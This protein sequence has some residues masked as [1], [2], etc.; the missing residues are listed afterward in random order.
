MK[1]FFSEGEEYRNKL[2]H[3]IKCRINPDFSPDRILDFGCGVGR[4]LLPMAE[5]CSSAVGTDVSR[6]MLEKAVL[7]CKE[8]GLDHVELVQS[9]DDLSQVDGS[10]DFIH[11]IYVFQHIPCSRGYKIFKQLLQKLSP[12]GVAMIQFTYD[13]DCSKRRNIMHWVKTHVPFALQIINL[14]RLRAP[15]TPIM[16]MHN[17]S[18][19]RLDRILHELNAAHCYTRYTKDGPFRGVMMFIQVAPRTGQEFVDMTPIP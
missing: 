5:K 3:V 2:F 9:D 6:A 13:N 8:A 7:H 16:E 17:Y 4:I 19:N 15:D 1:V 14:I 12:G 18:L 11:S 10:F